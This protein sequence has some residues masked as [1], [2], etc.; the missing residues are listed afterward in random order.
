[1]RPMLVTLAISIVNGFASPALTFGW[2]GLPAMGVRGNATGTLLSFVVA[3]VVT[4]AFLIHGDAGLQ[5]RLRYLKIVPTLLARVAKIGLP[6]WFEGMLLWTGQALIVM[7]VMRQVDKAVGVDGV[8][9]AGA[10][11]DAADRVAG[12]FAG[13]LALA[14]RARRWWGSI[15]GRKSRSRQCGRGCCAIGLRSRR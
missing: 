8:T 10:Q 12:V 2:F 1:M 7:L 14:S 4:F 13:G 9:M 5:L 11:C 6:S 3:G 15:W